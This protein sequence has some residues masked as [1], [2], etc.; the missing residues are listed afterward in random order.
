MC[1]C[2]KGIMQILMKYRELLENNLEN[3]IL[4]NNVV[5][6]KKDKFLDTY[7]LLKLN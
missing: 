1:V 5:Y 3:C 7:Y 4:K 6:L 2:I